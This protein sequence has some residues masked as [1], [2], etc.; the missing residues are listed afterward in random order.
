MEV[1]YFENSWSDGV[2]TASGMSGEPFLKRLSG[3]GVVGSIRS[4]SAK[5]G[6][7]LSRSD[8]CQAGG[9]MQVVLDVSVEAGGTTAG[10]ITGV[11]MGTTPVE[12]GGTIT[13][14]A[15]GIITVLAI[16]AG[17]ITEVTALD[18]TGVSAG[19]NI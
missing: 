19:T 4:R 5:S 10:A 9:V 7:L 17:T 18:T 12:T 1:K 6:I 11:T 15:G 3:E 13:V 2:F 14:L 8:S 16:G